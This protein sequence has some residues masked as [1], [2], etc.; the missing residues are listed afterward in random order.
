MT[1]RRRRRDRILINQP[2]GNLFCRRKQGLVSFGFRNQFPKPMETATWF[3]FKMDLVLFQDLVSETSFQ[4]FFKL[5]PDAVAWLRAQETTATTVFYCCKPMGS[6]T[7]CNGKCYSNGN[8]SSFHLV[9]ETSF[10]NQFPARFYFKTGILKKNQ[11]LLGMRLG[12]KAPVP[13]QAPEPSRTQDPECSRT[14]NAAERRIPER[15]RTQLCS[16]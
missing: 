13:A 10:G 3:F 7:N 15:S 9:S 8:R 4:F 5:P 12:R 2:A 11:A 6:I 14:Q 1:A 16:G